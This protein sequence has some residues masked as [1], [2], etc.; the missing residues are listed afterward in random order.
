MA[1]SWRNFFDNL[2]HDRTVLGT[3]YNNIVDW[4]SDVSSDPA[5]LEIPAGMVHTETFTGAVNIGENQYIVSQPGSMPTL[6]LTNS[7]T[8]IF[9]LRYGQS[10]IAGVKL[11]STLTGT[12]WGI[13]LHLLDSDAIAVACVIGDVAAPNVESLYAISLSQPNSRIALC[14]IGA[15]DWVLGETV[16]SV[17]ILSG[18]D[19]WAA[20]CTV[21]NSAVGIGYFS[22]SSLFTLTNCIAQNAAMVNTYADDGGSFNDLAASKN[23]IGQ[24]IRMTEDGYTPRVESI[25][26]G[27]IDMSE[28]PTFSFTDDIAGRIW[29]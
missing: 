4:K 28:N 23:L 22:S 3:D 9:S 26:T 10:G 6:N 13:V 20:N 25:N 8:T 29:G 14:A 2:S 27:G 11:N 21:N 1:G 24:N 7:Y 16:M 15:G 12:S 17:G 18:G 5:I 19:A